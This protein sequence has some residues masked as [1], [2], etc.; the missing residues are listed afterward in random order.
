MDHDSNPQGTTIKNSES[1]RIALALLDM[2]PVADIELD[3]E[4]KRL[5]N[6]LSPSSILFVDSKLV[7]QLAVF[8][9]SDV[10]SPASLE[11][12]QQVIAHNEGHYTAW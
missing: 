12:T 3:L 2:K 11:C 1:P 9:Q 6:L 5:S 8:L 7:S 10:L 4:C